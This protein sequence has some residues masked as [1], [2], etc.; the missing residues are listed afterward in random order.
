MNKPKYQI[1]ADE[2]K[3]KIIN[4]SY[5]AGMLLPTE[6]QFQSKFNVSRYTVRQAMNMLVQDGFIKKKKGSGSY[7]SYNFLNSNQSKASKKIGVIVTYVS[8]YIFP[9][10]ILSLIHI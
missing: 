9:S 8:D 5:H 3:E 2:I 6:K 1:V 10:I 4:K 7:V